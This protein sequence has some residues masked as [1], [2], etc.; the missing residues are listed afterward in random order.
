MAVGPMPG[1]SDA[2]AQSRSMSLQHHLKPIGI[3]LVATL[4]DE[5]S[6]QDRRALSH[7]LAHHRVYSKEVLRIIDLHPLG[8]TAIENAHLGTLD[9]AWRDEPQPKVVKAHLQAEGAQ[10]RDYGVLVSG[11]VELGDERQCVGSIEKMKR[12]SG[13]AFSLH[14]MKRTK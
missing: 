9:R 7:P 12:G 8:R 2:I 11:R 10:Q 1:E 6:P 3:L 13:Q 5:I 14:A 4:G